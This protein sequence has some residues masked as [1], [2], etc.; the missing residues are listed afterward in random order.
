MRKFGWTAAVVLSVTAL[1][2]NAQL[3]EI[4]SRHIRVFHP[5]GDFPQLLVRQNPPSGGGWKKVEAPELGFRLSVP[6]NATV[7]TKAAES[8]IVEVVFPTTPGKTRPVFRVD[9]FT[10]GSDDPTEVDA[11]YADR[12]AADY[13][14]AAFGGKFTVSDSGMVSSR[15]RKA[16]F[17]MVGGTYAQGAVAYYRVQWAYLAKD[18]QLFATFDCGARDWP[19]YADDVAQM[20]LSW[21]LDRKGKRK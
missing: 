7:D 5:R 12:Y 16:S 1:A 21:E 4:F 2:A 20:L 14:K 18:Q 10:P 11:D 9:R 8:R 19:A 15:D 3:E 13:S 17:A 6:A